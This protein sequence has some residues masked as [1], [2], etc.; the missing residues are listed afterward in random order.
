MFLDISCHM[1][2]LQVGAAMQIWESCIKSCN[3]RCVSS[4]GP[5]D[6]LANVQSRCL[7]TLDEYGK[8]MVH[9]LLRDMG[10]NMAVK[11][12]MHNKAGKRSHLCDPRVAER[13]LRENEVST[14]L[15][16]CVHDTF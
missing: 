6:S 10:R 11:S 15:N 3:P 9:D 5:N 2:G 13:V 14:T 16:R 4:Q 12:S 1:I 7:V 8:L